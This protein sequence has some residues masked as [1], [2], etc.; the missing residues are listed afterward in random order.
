LGYRGDA[1]VQ[2]DWA[3]GAILSTLDQTGLAD[4]TLVIF[5]SDNGPVYDD[6]Y[7]DGTT[8]KTSTEEVDRGHDGSGIYRGGKYQIYE[9]GTR[10]PLLVRW[11]A[12]VVSGVSDALI[13]QVDFLASFAQLLGQRIPA[14]AARDSR[15]QL[16]ALLGRDPKG[17]DVILEQAQG[18]AVRQGSWKYVGA[19]LKRKW[20]P[21]QAE[22]YDLSQDPS[23]AQNVVTGHPE[24]AEAMAALL[25]KFQT[26]G[27]AESH[28]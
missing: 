27:L 18:L 28:R 12:K 7:A 13:S 1:M 4:N 21:Q 9:G 10:V 15:S 20:Q 19:D 23:E 24:R 6:G 5:S 16:K 2:L 14:G 3:A 22:L 8:V 11:P 25:E 17:A 26:E